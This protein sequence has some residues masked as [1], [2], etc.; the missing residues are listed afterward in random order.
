MLSTPPFIF[1]CITVCALP[2]TQQRFQPFRATKF[3]LHFVGAV[4]LLIFLCCT[5]SPYQIP[6]LLILRHCQHGT[7]QIYTTVVP[8]VDRI[9]RHACTIC[10]K[11]LVFVA[12]SNLILPSICPR[13]AREARVEWKLVVFGTFQRGPFFLPK[14][15]PPYRRVCLIVQKE[16]TSYPNNLHPLFL[17][18]L[19][20]LHSL[21]IHGP[22]VHRAR[23]LLYLLL[24]LLLLLGRW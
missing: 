3:L 18:L 13:P 21:A 8:K 24:Q 7:N 5:Y 11:C 23:I 9:H 1:P 4:P 12:N 20:P 15:H 16:S 6:L 17:L 19:L 10:Q 2:F 14:F 22:R